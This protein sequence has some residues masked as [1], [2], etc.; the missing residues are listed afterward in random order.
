VFAAGP[1]AVNARVLSDA[2]ARGVWVN[3]AGGPDRG[4]FSLP[5]AFRRGDLVLA[6][7]T[8]GAAPALAGSVRRHLEAEFDETFG[9]WVLLLAEVR[10]LVLEGVADEGRRR[11]LLTSLCQWEWLERLRREGA[12]AVRE[13]MLAAV[14]AESGHFRGGASR[15][16]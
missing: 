3:A 4:D 14:E 13:A 8:G 5:A 6:V 1:P 2:R 9:A 16:T 11:A 15:S 10:P 12:G 7:S